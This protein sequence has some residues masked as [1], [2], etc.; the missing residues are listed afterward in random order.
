MELMKI[1]VFPNYLTSLVTATKL[2]KRLSFMLSV[3]LFLSL[4]S[5]SYENE[6]VQVI[7][8]KTEY[9]KE[10]ICIGV[11]TPRL[12]WRFVGNDPDFKTSKVE[13]NLWSNPNKTGKKIT[14]RK[15]ADPGDSPITSAVVPEK[16]S[17]LQWYY[18]EITAWD[19]NGTKCPVSE[20]GSFKT[21]M[22]SNDDW[23]AKRITDGHGKDY[24]P[25]PLFRKQFKIEGRKIVSAQAYISSA[26]YN[27]MYI[28]GKRVGDSFMNPAFTNFSKRL[29]Y[30]TYDVT[31]LLVSGENKV[32]AVL[33]NGRYNFQGLDSWSLASA[34]WRNRVSLMAEI[35]IS[36][37]DGTSEIISTDKSWKTST[38]K[39]FYN[40]I[41]S[42]DYVDLRLEETGW[43]ENNFD[44]SGWKQAQ[45]INLSKPRIVSRQMPG[46]RITEEYKASGFKKFSDQLYVYSFPKNMAGFCR[47]KVKGIRGT[48]IKLRHA[49]MLKDDGRVEME[50]V[51]IFFTPNHEDEQAQSDEIILRDPDEVVEFSPSFTFH[52]FQ[53]VE[54]ESSKPINLTK[55]SLTAFFA[56]TDVESVGSFECSNSTLNKI[57]DATR[58]S[59]LSNLESIPM[60]CPQ[61]E[62]NGWIGDAQFAIDLGLLNYDGISFYE[63]WMDD[64]IDAQ[65]ERGDLTA[66]IPSSGWGWAPGPVWDAALFIIPSA[67]YNYYDDPHCIEKMLPTIDRY[68]AYMEKEEKEGLITFGLGDWVFLKTET[69]GTFTSSAYYFLQYKLRASF[70]KIT[71]ADD[72]KYLAKAEEIRKAINDKFYDP[73][74]G[75]YAGGTQTAQGLALYVGLSPE[76]EEQKV[77][78]KLHELV[79]GNNY[80]LDFGVIGSKTVPRMLTKYG[81]VED[82]MKMVSKTD[83]PSWGYWVE[84]KGY[85]TLPEAWQWTKIQDFSSLN[86][87]FLGDVSA[88]M[89]NDLAG[90]NY[91][92]RNPGFKQILITPHFVD[93]LSWVRAQYRSVKGLISS[94]WKRENEK[95]ILNVTIPVGCSALINPGNGRQFVVKGGNY[96]FT[97]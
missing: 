15:E 45:E 58:Q 85:T 77:A 28:N 30:E 1:Y 56:H 13:V 8:L 68:L 6:K 4:A 96:E 67:L 65:N 91:D 41:Y 16:L 94:E 20:L 36:Y 95:I 32:V 66:I 49:E 11:S 73:E 14:I 31:D 2:V 25:A 62:K 54:V 61:R 64:F 75:A 83:F 71:G 35:H 34:P 92:A 97:F 22:F 59:Y 51:S 80:F 44:D 26:G 63:K 5:C 69:D 53:H 81:Y 24:G 57:W 89:V 17:P 48:K 79:A 23:Q 50:S 7:D 43:K 21:A 78:D 82:A 19:E 76:G 10:P 88:W 46:I 74:T 38:G 39:L 87:V 37:S 86:H 70:A 93:S 3:F 55:E 40:N 60:D 27:E 33:G 29:L 9:L 42:G 84:K 47:L 52:G 72:S 90:I 18:W 12:T